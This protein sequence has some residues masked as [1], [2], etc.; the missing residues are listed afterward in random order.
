VQ[1]VP[2]EEADEIGGVFGVCTTALLIEEHAYKGGP[3]IIRVKA[4]AA[5]CPEE[6]VTFAVNG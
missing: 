1:V 6:S 3:Q 5:F 2:V 4:C